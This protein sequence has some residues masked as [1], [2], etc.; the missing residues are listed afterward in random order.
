MFKS[1]YNFYFPIFY[2]ILHIRFSMSRKSII[3]QDINRIQFQNQFTLS[4]N[5]ILNS[6]DRLYFITAIRSD[7]SWQMNV[8]G[9]N[10]DPNFRNYSRK[11]NGD[12]QFMIPICA[13]EISFTG[14]IEFS[15]FWINSSLSSH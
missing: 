9:N 8:K 12:F 3:L 13:N 15:G 14:V 6:N 10:S 11:G 2:F 7:G 5:S 4:G 1:F